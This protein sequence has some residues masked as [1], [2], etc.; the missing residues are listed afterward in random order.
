M[1]NAAFTGWPRRKLRGTIHACAS[2]TNNEDHAHLEFCVGHAKNNTRVWSYKW[3]VPYL[4]PALKRIQQLKTTLWWFFAMD[5]GSKWKERSMSNCEKTE[6]VILFIFLLFIILSCTTV[7]V[8]NRDR[9]LFSRIPNRT[10]TPK[11]HLN[12]CHNHKRILK[13]GFGL[14]KAPLVSFKSI[15]MDKTIFKNLEVY[16]NHPIFIFSLFFFHWT[17][18]KCV[19][20]MGIKS[21]EPSFLRL[22]PCLWP[23]F[24]WNVM[25][26][27][28]LKQFCFL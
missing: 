5:I 25:L 27:C 8:H 26:T 15:A 7:V 14:S 3:P 10:H 23:I 12:S 21:T 13:S 16:L 4:K 24:I 19:H 18:A 6:I 17:T 9:P 2:I 22:S 1:G 11:L 20:L 28:T